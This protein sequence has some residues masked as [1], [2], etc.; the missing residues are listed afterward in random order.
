MTNTDAILFSK[1]FQLAAVL[2]YED[3]QFG[4]YPHKIKF[5]EAAWTQDKDMSVYRL[6]INLEFP[7]IR[8]QRYKHV[9]LNVSNTTYDNS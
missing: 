3:P 7:K 9:D 1:H 6:E 2:T 5:L 8:L 4:L